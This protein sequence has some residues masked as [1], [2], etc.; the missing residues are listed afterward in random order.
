MAY[1]ELKLKMR[2]GKEIY[3]Y[4]WK[5]ET[6]TSYKGVVQII[7]GMAEYG[8]RYDGFAKEL[9]KAGYIVYADDH[10]GHGKSAE[11]LKDLGYISDNDGFHTM[12]HDQGEIISFIKR[13]NPQ[14][15]VY[16][17]GHSMGSFISQRY[18]E[19]YGDTVNGVILSCTNGKP[20]AIMNFGIGLSKVLMCFT[21]R[22]GSGKLIDKIGF[23]SYNDK[24]DTKRTKFD[25]LSRNEKEVDKYILD[26]YCGADFPVSFFYDFLKGMKSIH[27]KENLSQIPRE[28]PIQ[29]FSGD[30]DPVGEYGK[31]VKALFEELKELGVKN[32]NCKL[33]PGGRHEIVNET[34]KEE[35]ISDIIATLDA[36]TKAKEREAVTV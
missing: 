13:E 4:Q 6:C 36:W 21:G 22:R 18:M 17:F 31:G 27:I 30:M 33:Y 5:D 29:L 14:A 23:G 8:S 15:K 3:L 19:L 35:V 16:I 11:S 28:L 26:P 1:K 25:W 9:V 34:N 20:S 2:D 24:Y 32:I 7:H 10:R 12:V